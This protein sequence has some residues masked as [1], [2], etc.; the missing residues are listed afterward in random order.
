MQSLRTTLFD[1]FGE[2]R[3]PNYTYET[4]TADGRRRVGFRHGVWHRVVNGM[5][6]STVRVV[7]KPKYG[8]HV[9]Q[10]LLLVGGGS[11]VKA[12]CVSVSTFDF[13]E[14]TGLDLRGTDM[15][16]YPMKDVRAFF[17][18]A[19]KKPVEPWSTVTIM[20]WELEND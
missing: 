13:R 11:E 10:R 2:H 12:R 15:E 14:L 1:E 8:F 6:S 9:G 20:T 18:S 16:N 3:R 4:H 5:L 19:H 7:H 17:E